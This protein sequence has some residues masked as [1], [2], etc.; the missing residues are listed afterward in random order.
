MP[1]RWLAISRWFTGSSFCEPYPGSGAG[2]ESIPAPLP[3]P[4]CFL[5]SLRSVL[6]D[7]PPPPIS[8]RASARSG[9][10]ATPGLLMALP[11]APETR[12]FGDLL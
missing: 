7:R 6:K 5:E 12:T 3:P 9:S 2:R 1:S 10:K 4:H 8:Q 11:G